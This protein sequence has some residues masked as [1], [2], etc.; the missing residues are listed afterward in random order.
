MLAMSMLALKYVACHGLDPL[1]Y[2]PFV[3]VLTPLYHRKRQIQ[4]MILHLL[5]RVKMKAR[6]A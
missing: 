6:T 5:V 1:S 2:T 3:Q 4:K